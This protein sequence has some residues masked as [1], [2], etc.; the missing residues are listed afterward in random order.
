MQIPRTLYHDGKIQIKD[1][2]VELVAWD[3]SGDSSWS[4]EKMTLECQVGPLLKKEV[5]WDTDQQAP[6]V[7]PDNPYDEHST[8]IK[9]WFKAE[10]VIEIPI[11]SNV[12]YWSNGY[13]NSTIGQ[14]ISLKNEDGSAYQT[15]KLNL[16]LH[17]EDNDYWVYGDPSK[18]SIMISADS[19]GGIW[20]GNVDR[21]GSEHPMI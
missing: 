14:I 11:E 17:T 7:N 16:K 18:M 20:I 13:Y 4:A 5:K 6:S 12:T 19:R 1:M 21:D 8:A 9:T 3:P 2:R 10:E 15:T